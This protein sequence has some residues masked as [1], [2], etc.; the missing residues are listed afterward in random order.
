MTLQKSKSCSGYNQ[1]FSSP[2][3][4]IKFDKYKYSM[5][6]FTKLDKYL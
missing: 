1:T 6:V 4:T 3:G 2:I 5:M